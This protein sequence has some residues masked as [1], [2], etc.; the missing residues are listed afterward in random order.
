MT[1]AGHMTVGLPLT[2]ARVLCVFVHGR[3][4]SPEEMERHV[5]SR[6][7]ETGA[8]FVLPRSPGGSWYDARAVDPLT[9]TTRRQLA[10]ALDVLGDVIASARQ[11]MRRGTPMLLAGF[12][13]GAC[14]S[15]EYAMASGP[16]PGALACL[17]G[18]RVG[19]A[20]STRPRSGLNGLAAYLSGSDA[21][22]WIPLAA[23]A[24]AAAELGRAKAK[25]RA[26]LFPGRPHEVSQTE[27]GVREAALRSLARDTQ[28]SPW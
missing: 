15:L 3:G 17:T 10:A 14:L 18:C 8:A 21:D 16:W 12:S 24:D 27:I 1:A 22:P 5:L 19:V 13:Q 25:L 4:Q 20:A 23:W 2:E 7:S 11:A 6:L 28:A 9:D 26:D